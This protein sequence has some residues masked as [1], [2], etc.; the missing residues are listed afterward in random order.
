VVITLLVLAL[1]KLASRILGAKGDG[2]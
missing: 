2:S 1:L